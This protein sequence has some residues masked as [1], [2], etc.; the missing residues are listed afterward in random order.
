MDEA[1]GDI[2][3]HIFKIIGNVYLLSTDLLSTLQFRICT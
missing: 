2:A 1:P 3:P